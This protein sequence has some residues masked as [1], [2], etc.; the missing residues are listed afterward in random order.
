MAKW[1]P[2]GLR[3]ISGLLFSSSNQEGLVLLFPAPH[4][5]LSRSLVVVRMGAGSSLGDVLGL[6][7]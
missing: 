2:H 5:S 4:A 3:L 6:R 1:E 7:D